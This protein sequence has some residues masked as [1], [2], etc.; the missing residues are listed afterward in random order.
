[1]Q[2]DGGTC[3]EATNMFMSAII[4]CEC[5]KTRNPIHSYTCVF[6]AMVHRAQKWSLIKNAETVQLMAS[7]RA[8]VNSQLIGQAARRSS[9]LHFIVFLFLLTRPTNALHGLFQSSPEDR[10]F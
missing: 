4:R 10:I 9:Y 8:F 3:D 6:A 1:L 2:T 5:V 7:L